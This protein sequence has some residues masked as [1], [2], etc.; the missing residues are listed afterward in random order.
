MALEP[1]VFDLLSYVI[2]NR[3]RV[4]DK[5]DLVTAVWGGRVISNSTLTDAHQC[6][7]E[8][9]GKLGRGAAA[10]P[11][12]GAQGHPVGWRSEREQER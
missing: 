10:D 9:T 3:N 8:G 4:V 1:Q 5:D 6:D 7:A 11:H 12:G 2:S